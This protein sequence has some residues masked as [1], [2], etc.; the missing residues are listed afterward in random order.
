MMEQV[1]VP[2]LCGQV[3]WRRG[4]GGGIQRMVG[5]MDIR[6]NLRACLKE[7]LCP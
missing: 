1:P 5:L 7:D 3:N 4:S 6:G 2:V